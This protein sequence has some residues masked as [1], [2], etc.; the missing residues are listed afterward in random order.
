MELID[1]YSKVYSVYLASINKESEKAAL[2]NKAAIFFSFFWD[3]F[4]IV[5]GFISDI[6]ECIFTSNNFWVIF[7][8]ILVLIIIPFIAFLFSKL[9]VYLVVIITKRTVF[10]KRKN[11]RLVENFY[12]YIYP[13]FIHFSNL[14]NILDKLN[15]SLEIKRSLSLCFKYFFNELKPIIT[16]SDLITEDEHNTTHILVSDKLFCQKIA[17]D[18]K[19]HLQ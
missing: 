1:L 3:A 7:V 4:L 17:N 8:F 5:F 15:N 2:E 19:N 6:Y 10:C 11:A 13:A 9:I 18:L 16:N 12:N 14:N